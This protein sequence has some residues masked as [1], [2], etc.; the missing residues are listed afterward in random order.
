[1]PYNTA[2]EDKIEAI[3]PQWEGLEKKKMFGGIGFLV[4]GNLACG[5]NKNDLIVRVGPEKHKEALARAHT[6]I[7]N[8]TGRPMAGWIMV[9]PEGCAS[10]RELNGWIQQ[11]IAFAHSLPAKEK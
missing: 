8:M 10:E 7:F 1:M 2:L 5:V 6:R 4:N 11:G 9:D 3:V